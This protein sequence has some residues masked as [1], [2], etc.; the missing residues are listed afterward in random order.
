MVG[1]NLVWRDKTRFGRCGMAR[2]G[3][4]GSGRDRLGEAGMARSV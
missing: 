2:Q 1:Q 4:F 3:G